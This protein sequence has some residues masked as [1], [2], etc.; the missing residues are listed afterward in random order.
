MNMTRKYEVVYQY[1]P[2]ILKPSCSDVKALRL[3]VQNTLGI[4][5]EHAAR[6]LCASMVPVKPYTWRL[7]EE[8]VTLPKEAHWELVNVKLLHILRVYE[9]GDTEDV[10]FEHYEA[11]ITRAIRAKPVARRLGIKHKFVLQ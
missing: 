7:W 8:N 3:N 2:E 4:T 5:S 1:N 11:A 10:V 6:S 9:S